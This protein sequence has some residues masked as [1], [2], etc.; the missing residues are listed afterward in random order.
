MYI[1][2][3]F[4]QPA[5][6]EERGER[7]KKREC[8]VTDGQTT[9]G[10]GRFSRN[11]WRT[12]VVVVRSGV[13]KRVRT[14]GQRRGT[15]SPSPLSPTTH[16][17]GKPKKQSKKCAFSIITSLFHLSNNRNRKSHIVLPSYPA[18]Y[19]NMGGVRLRVSFLL[20]CVVWG[21]NHAMLHPICP[22]A[23]ASNALARVCRSFCGL[24]GVL[25]R[26]GVLREVASQAV[27]DD[28]PHTPYFPMPIFTLHLPCLH[29]TLPLHPPT[30]SSTTRP[31]FFNIV[32][33]SRRCNCVASSVPSSP[34]YT[35]RTT[36][37]SFLPF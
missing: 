17:K 6:T 3:S 14:W 5:M 26:L 2:S 36:P 24:S 31:A 28:T 16:Q 12:H 21:L 10:L 22:A 32:S 30:Y 13:R 37:E 18:S 35:A 34:Q 33:G 11:F 29:T 9:Q 27:V 1:N 20:V 19:G 7:E 23:P 8:R 25:G 4:S 15:T